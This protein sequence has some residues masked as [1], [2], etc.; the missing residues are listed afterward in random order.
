MIY[1]SF[2]FPIL[3]HFASARKIGLKALSFVMSVPF[4]RWLFRL[5]YCRKKYEMTTELFGI[6]FPGPIALADGFD[7]SANHFADLGNLGFSYVSIGPFDDSTQGSK[8]GYLWTSIR[9]LQL[10][11]SRKVR[12]A[13]VLEGDCV[14][15]FSLL[16]DFVDFFCVK[17][18][19]DDIQ[20]IAQTVDDLLEMRL[21]YDSDKPMVIKILPHTDM[22][23][24]H[25]ALD[26]CRFSGIDA[27]ALPCEY[28][29]S[30][31]EYTGG[32]LPIIAYGEGM[33][34][35]KTAA[36]LAAGATMVEIDGEFPLEGPSVVKKYI[37]YIR[38]NSPANK[39]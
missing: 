31:Q 27:V 4:V 8:D 25:A 23:M 11:T 18:S 10:K 1:K 21:C 38:Q 13:A 2:I 9:N 20:D 34:A 19:S 37:K 24:L 15:S 33:T 12:V 29:S 32:R 5:R 6:Q 26:Y 3:G 7:P 36:M 35:E 28:V 16:Y 14:K 39:S 17:M 30:A 22:D